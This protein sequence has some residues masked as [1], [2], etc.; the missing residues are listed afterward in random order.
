MISARRTPLDSRPR[1]EHTGRDSR[2]PPGDRSAPA[3]PPTRVHRRR[4]TETTCVKNGTSPAGPALSLPKGQVRS[5]RTDRADGVAGSDPRGR[6]IPGIA[7]FSVHCLSRLVGYSAAS[8]ARGFHGGGRQDRRWSVGERSCP[9]GPV[10]ARPPRPA[11]LAWPLP[12][13][14]PAYRALPTG[15][16]PPARRGTGSPVAV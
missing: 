11:A 16:I 10:C 4:S 15:N 8:P 1:A 13:V 3:S 9:R 2:G 6:R 14:T 5:R 7:P 12:F